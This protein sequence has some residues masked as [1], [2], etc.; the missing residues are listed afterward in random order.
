[1]KRIWQWYLRNVA[2]MALV[3][4]AVLFGSVFLDD[5]TEAKVVR[6]IM[7]PAAITIGT[8]M[9]QDHRRRDKAI[10]Q[11]GYDQGHSDAN[12]KQSD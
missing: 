6:W 4:M 2:W 12:S 1:M 11:R 7:L 5:D 10:W 3:C 9:W 8:V